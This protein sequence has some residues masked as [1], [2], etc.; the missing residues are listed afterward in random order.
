[1]YDRIVPHSTWCGCWFFFPKQIFISDK[2]TRKYKWSKEG[3]VST[4][5][6]IIFQNN[7]LKQ[8]IK[9]LAYCIVL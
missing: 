6:L 1:M 4:F 8:Q 7:E 2:C 9:M 3:N 5:F